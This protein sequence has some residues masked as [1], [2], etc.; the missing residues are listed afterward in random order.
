MY[1][2]QNNN[3]IVLSKSTT[4]KIC[5]KSN[6][7]IIVKNKP[8]FHKRYLRKRILFKNI[9]KLFTNNDLKRNGIHTF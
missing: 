3:R 5:I 7:Y 6:V 8:S 2:S 9:T 4:K 1:K